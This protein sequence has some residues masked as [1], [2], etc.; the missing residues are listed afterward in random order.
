MFFKSIDIPT[1]KFKHVGVLFTVLSGLAE[2]LL[3]KVNL[4]AWLGS[5]LLGRN[6]IH[7]EMFILFDSKIQIVLA[8][9][10]EQSTQYL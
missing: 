4:I 9:P 10:A 1:Q 2:G 3:G 6:A 8:L 7:L 5:Y